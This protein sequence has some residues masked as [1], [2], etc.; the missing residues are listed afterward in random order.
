M[1][2]GEDP[3]VDLESLLAYWLGESEDERTQAIDAHL[4]GCERCGAELDQLIALQASV[5]RAFAD[6]QVNA[7][8][9]GSFV[10][11]L[12][13]QGMRVHEHLLPHN[14]SVNCSA[15][16][17]DDLLVARL[18]APLDGVDRLDAVF[19]SS[20]EADE[21]R[22]SDIPFDPRAGEVVMI[23]KLAEVRGLPAHDF[24]VRLVSC[25]DGSERTVGEYMLH[26]SPTAGR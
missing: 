1:S 14:G 10:R 15:A 25:R 18:Q 6:G 8:V 4:L 21:Y 3:H 5:R 20:I 13:E 2:R 17:D 19:R 16:P 12:A 24:T 23:P 26:H 11:R 22:L 9:S 7:F